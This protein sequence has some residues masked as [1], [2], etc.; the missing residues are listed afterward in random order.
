MKEV[1]KLERLL[2]NPDIGKEDDF[3]KLYFDDLGRLWDLSK[4]TQKV[5][6]EIVRLVEYNPQSSMHNLISL[7]STKKS[8][9]AKKLGWK[10]SSSYSQFSQAIKEMCDTEILHKIANDTLLLN[11]AIASKANWADVKLLRSI[12]LEIT[13][14]DSQRTLTTIVESLSDSQ[15]QDLREILER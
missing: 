6:G 5:F 2:G 4:P 8:V 12:K 11:P 3:I 10:K 7:N 9:I 15:K 14:E 13:Y 1:S